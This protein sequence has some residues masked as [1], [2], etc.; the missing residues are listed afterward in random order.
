MQEFR[1]CGQI[2]AEV[3]SRSREAAAGPEPGGI[4]SPSGSRRIVLEAHDR[5]D[6]ALTYGHNDGP[7]P[8]RGDARPPLVRYPSHISLS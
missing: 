2:D 8:A 4:A 5:P 6:P 7:V 3:A 1:E